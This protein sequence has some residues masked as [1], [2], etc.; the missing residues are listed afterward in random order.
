MERINDEGQW[1]VLMG[2]IV[3]VA[4]FVLAIIVNQSVTV[5]QTTSEAVLEFPKNEITEFREAVIDIAKTEPSSDILRKD[6][7]A[8]SMD[9][10][11]AV[12]YYDI[13]AKYSDMYYSYDEIGIRFNNGVTKYNE[14]YL[15]AEK[16]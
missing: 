7:Y 16:I 5:G 6:L 10:M 3:S 12:V 15:L 4:L 14:T 1:I 8:L 13:G 9:R 11:D 2:F